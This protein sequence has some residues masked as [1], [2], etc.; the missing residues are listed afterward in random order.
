[1]IGSSLKT[2]YLA[3]VAAVLAV[4][5]IVYAQHASGRKTGEKPPKVSSVGPKVHKSNT[6][7]KRLLTSEQYAVMR[8]QD[9]GQPFS[10]K[11]V[12]F[13]AKGIYR[14]AACG[15][16]LFSSNTKF[17]SGTGWPSFW[18]PIASGHVYTRLDNSF[19]ETRTEVL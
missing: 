11:Y 13:K 16:D 15:N 7:W 17:D 9:T 2:A 12:H 10:G 5:A 3:P 1:M 18:A 19:G 14:C 4:C 6:E 8:R